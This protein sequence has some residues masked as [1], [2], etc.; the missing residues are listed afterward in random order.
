MLEEKSKYSVK[1]LNKILDVL[2]ANGRNSFVNDGNPD[3]KSYIDTMDRI[4]QLD[5]MNLI[6]EIIEN[7]E[8]IYTKYGSQPVANQT[9]I[10]GSDRNDYW[11]LYASTIIALD[12]TRKYEKWVAGNKKIISAYNWRAPTINT[13][14]IVYY[15]PNYE[16][17]DNAIHTEDFGFTQSTDYDMLINAIKA[18]VITKEYIEKLSGAIMKR[19][20]DEITLAEQR[21]NLLK[22]LILER[23]GAVKPVARTRLEPIHIQKD[24]PEEGTK[25]YH[26]LAFVIFIAVIAVTVIGIVWLVIGFVIWLKSSHGSVFMILAGPFAIIKRKNIRW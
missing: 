16:Y 3:Y 21:N 2:S 18:D 23:N 7:R 20:D 12:R 22:Y 11:K 26:I 14:G 8:W 13:N 17:I 5:Y 9:S 15:D 6:D 25:W 1:L 10:D 24:K 19:I 4:D